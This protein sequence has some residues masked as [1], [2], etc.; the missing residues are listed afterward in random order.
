M[1][2]IVRSTD[3]CLG[4][5]LEGKSDVEVRDYFRDILHCYDSAEG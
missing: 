1:R 4:S 2:D 5:V 3:R